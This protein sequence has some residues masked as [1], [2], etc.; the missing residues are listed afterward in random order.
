MT[1]AQVPKE[2]RSRPF[3]TRQAAAL[4]LSRN[5]LQS[6]QWRHVFREVWVH[7]AL[8]DNQQLRLD[9][10]RL[11]LGAD[12]FVCGLTAAWIQG[13]DA[14]DRHADLVWVG[15]PIGRRVRRRTGCLVREL[16]IE[17]DEIVTVRGVRVTRPLRTAFD[18]ARWLTL[19]EATV[20]TDALGHGGKIRARDV[21]AYID[22]RPGWRGV[23]AA[24][25]VVTLMDARSES[26]METRLRLLLVLA[27]LPAPQPQVVVTDAAGRFVA[28]LDLAYPDIGLA[29]E[30][31]GAWHWNQRRADDRRRQAVRDLGWDVVVVSAEDYYRTPDEL[32]A[33]IATKLGVAITKRT[34]RP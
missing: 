25:L 7:N 14:H 34:R 30:Y 31:D 15:C 24:R 12:A 33:M 26:P 10:V 20:V 13:V 8:E 16:E 2:L 18:C 9:A 28:R 27:G 1:R 29:I 23:R 19:V 11:V 5:A 22:Q 4:G 17:D 6:A 3:T 32:V 21:S